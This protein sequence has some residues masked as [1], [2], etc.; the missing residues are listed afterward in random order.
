[1]IALQILL[2]FAVGVATIITVTGVLFG[3]INAMAVEFFDLDL[4]WRH[5]AAIYATNFV[6]CVLLIN[7]CVGYVSSHPCGPFSEAQNCEQVDND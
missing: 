2:I 3:S 7:L 4:N 6:A 5:H 1:M